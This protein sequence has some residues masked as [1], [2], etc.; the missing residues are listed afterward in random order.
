MNNEKVLL[1]TIYP[2][3]IPY[4]LKKKKKIL[5]L[6]LWCAAETKN[7]AGLSWVMW[8]AD[9]IE[10]AQYSPFNMAGV[11]LVF[12]L[13]RSLYNYLVGNSDKF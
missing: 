5:S 4:S 12:F 2:T 3:K 10:M 9:L 6:P 1:S 7:L 8:P 11:L 13:V